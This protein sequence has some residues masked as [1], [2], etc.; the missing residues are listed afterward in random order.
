MKQQIVITL[1]LFL[2]ISCK[3]LPS[4]P[5]TLGEANSAYTYIPIDPLPVFE[6]PGRSCKEVENELAFKDLL[7]SLPDQAVRLAIAQLNGSASGSFGPASIGYEN[8]SY[9]VVLDYISVDA[10]QLPV[11]LKRVVLSGPRAGERVPLYD[12]LPNTPTRYVVKG[13]PRINPY[14]SSDTEYIR[15]E[16]DGEL[17]VFPVYIGV[18]LRLTATVDVIEGNVNL[19]SLASIAAEAQAEKLTGSLTVQTLGITGNNVSTS[20]PLPSEINQST[21]QNAILSLGSIKA[22]LYD[23]ENTKITPRVVG[24]YNPVGGG[25][26]VVNGII[27]VL[28]ENPIVW[29]RPCK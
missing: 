27:S 20:L 16:N 18:G 26:E 1:T 10:T 11:Y 4:L 13:A 19:S 9:Q 3:S 14:A 2:L 23:E 28:A 5:Q 15:N 6:E 17:V 22:V 25:Q 8:N 21:V 7:E 12:E 24:I 29:Y